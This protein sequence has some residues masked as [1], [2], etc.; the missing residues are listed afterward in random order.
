MI[1][2]YAFPTET[3]KSVYLEH[4]DI[5][6]RMVVR[7]QYAQGRSQMRSSRYPLSGNQAQA[8]YLIERIRETLAFYQRPR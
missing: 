6:N 7:V 3:V 8:E 2:S 4:Y 1:E 5:A